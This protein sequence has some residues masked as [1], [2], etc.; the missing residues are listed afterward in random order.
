[1]SLGFTKC[2]A[3]KMYPILNYAPRHEDLKQATKAWSIYHQRSEINFCMNLVKLESFHS[4]TTGE[5]DQD[6]TRDQD[7]SFAL[8][9]YVQPRQT[10]DSHRGAKRL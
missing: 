3:M 2:H 7:H 1:M 5:V 10:E 9:L 6:I 8:L 4:P